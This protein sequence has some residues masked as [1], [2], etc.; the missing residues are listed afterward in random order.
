MAK[1]LLKRYVWL[2]DTINT[3][4]KITFQEISDK[5][6]RSDLS[7]GEELPLRTF[8]NHKKA[9][10]SLLE[11]DIKCEKRTNSYY[12]SGINDIESDEVATWLINSFTVSNLIAESQSLKH[13]IILENIP[14][15]QR[16]LST[17]IKAMR[18]G[19]VLNV[20]YQSY[21]K[22]A[23]DVF[24]VEPYFVKL[25]RQRWY[26]IGRSPYYDAIRVYSL[27]RIQ[28]L[29]LS[30]KSFRMPDNFEAEDFFF[31]SY[32]IITDEKV[33]ATTVEIKVWEKQVRYL[34]DLPLHHSQKESLTSSDYSH[35]TYFLK[36]TDDFIQELLSQGD[37]IEVLR[38]KWLREEIGRIVANMG[39]YYG[40][41]NLE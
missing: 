15:G 7:D 14:S 30:K 6:Q 21:W 11:I 12:I 19:N 4:G 20:C 34:R 24:E 35:F 37:R 17:I 2:V 41:L 8:H 38:P 22:N 39:Q 32:G 9:I 27:D 23:P 16:Y 31:N 1:D 26:V 18:E 5:W 33:K 25:F 13:R 10:R 29:E 40:G 3:A 28:E 36:P